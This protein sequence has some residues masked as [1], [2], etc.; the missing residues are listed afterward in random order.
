[1]VTIELIHDADC[2]NAERAR[3]ALASALATAGLPSRWHEWE[4]G[5]PASPPW[6]QGWGSPT[7]L[8]DGLDVA[9]MEPGD[10]ASSC[11]VYADPAGGLRGTPTVETI[12]AALE[13]AMA[14]SEGKAS[15][16]PERASRRARRGGW[17]APL[18]ALPGIGVSMLPIGLC[19]AC[20][21]AYAGLLGALGLGA[22][23]ETRYVLALTVV[24]LAIALAALAWKAKLRRGWGPFLLGLV[25]AAM[26]LTGKFVLDSQPVSYGGAGL[27]IAA[28]IWNAWPLRYHDDE[29][30]NEVT[31]KD[32][33][34]S[35]ELPPCCQGR[36]QT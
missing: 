33:R 23:I 1:M 25:A 12:V 4:R 7:I 20:W 27:L 14:T 8:V 16:A 32:N 2:P 29:N 17:L 5:D 18:A 35:A 21:P 11:R 34:G 26:L 31:G 9:G 24:F 19:P 15:P 3:A 22:L 30:E 10:G 28:S 6:V 13:R 36:T